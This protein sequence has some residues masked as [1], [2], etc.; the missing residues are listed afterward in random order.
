MYA[1]KCSETSPNSLQRRSPS[2]CSSEV[3]EKEKLQADSCPANL[4]QSE[5]RKTSRPWQGCGREE[6]QGPE[7]EDTVHHHGRDWWLWHCQ[8]SSGSEEAALSAQ[9]FLEFQCSKQYCPSPYIIN[10]FYKN[11]LSCQSD[12]DHLPDWIPLL[13]FAFYLCPQWPFIRVRMTTWSQW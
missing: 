4:H 12:W 7:Q 6:T 8:I 13:F 3:W 5:S 10:H 9:T 1:R 11:I 2:C